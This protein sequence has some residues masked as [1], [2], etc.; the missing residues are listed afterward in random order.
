[1]R[2]NQMSRRTF[3]L[4]NTLAGTTVMALAVMVLAGLSQ[5][6]VNITQSSVP[7]VGLAGYHTHTLTANTDDGSQIQGFDF[8]SQPS[9]GFLG[10]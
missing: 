3:M 4:R 8:G 9:F 6:A 7:T 1:M 10:R 2:A 5:A